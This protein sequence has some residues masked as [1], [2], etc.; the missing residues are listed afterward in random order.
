MDEHCMEDFCGV[1]IMMHLLRM[2]ACVFLLFLCVSASVFAQTNPYFRTVNG[3][4][5]IP[6][7]TTAPASAADGSFYI[8]NSDKVLY[9]YEGTKWIPVGSGVIPKVTLTSASALYK[10]QVVVPDVQYIYSGGLTPS[11]CAVTGSSYAWYQASD[12]QGTG[13]TI[14][15]SGTGTP[16][17]YT[18]QSGDVGKYI[19]FGITPVTACNASTFETVKWT[20]VVGLVPS[21]AS[22]NVTGLAGSYAIKGNV[23]AAS[24]SG[25]TCTPVQIAGDAGSSSTY[26]WYYANDASGTGKTAIAGKT[27]SGY[28][29]SF[30]DGYPAGKYLAVGVLPVASNSEV[31]FEKMSAWYPS[32][33]LVPAY[34]VVS[35]VGL[36]EGKAQ[37]NTTLAAVTGLYSVSVSLNGTEAN[38]AYQWYYATS[39]AGAGKTAITGQTARTHIINISGG[40]GYTNDAYYLAVGVTPVTTTGEVGAETLSN[41]VKIQVIR[42]L[43]G[44]LVNEVQSPSGRIW[45]DRNLGSSRVATGNNDYL[46][47]GS[48]FQW[49]RAADGHQLINWTNASSGSAVNSITTSLSATMFPG[50]SNFIQSTTGLWT[51]MA[52]SDGSYWW[53]G[54]VVGATNPCPAQYHVPTQSEW[55]VEIT[56]NAIATLKLS[57]AGY[58]DNSTSALMN[59]GSQGYYWS[60]TIYTSPYAYSLGYNVTASIA[61]GGGRN[62]GFSVRCIK[63]L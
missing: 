55:Q 10:G 30:S 18:I 7:L 8:N 45:M 38:P 57:N 54:S 11:N 42:S 5:Y 62:N 56:A 13:K 49:C 4:S 15:T 43:D 2:E 51:N 14:I 20:P 33:S 61:S 40:Y 32:S 37:N 35:I 34:N 19:G 39:A 28:T 26:Q 31:G 59:P 53:S 52:Q 60:S 24:F 58:R 27:A 29:V 44:T 41:W 48:L 63:D 23:L 25:Y 17:S 46:A 47:Y 9:K 22:V 12:G 36:T 3:I 1:K 6:V 50:H 21:V 16:T